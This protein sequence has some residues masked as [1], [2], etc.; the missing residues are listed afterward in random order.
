MAAGA[1]VTGAARGI[2][3]AI[4]GRLAREGYAVTA[5]DH[6]ASGLADAAARIAAQG[7]SLRAVAMDVTDRAAVRA[8]AQCIE[9]LEVV[10]NNAGVASPMTAFEAI[11]PDEWRR[12]LGVNTKGVFI[13]T[14]E[15]L[16]VLRPGG[17]IINIASRGYLGGA[18]AAHYVASKAAVVGLTRALAVELRWR[19]ISVNA[20]A[21]GMVDTPMIAAFTPQEMSALLAREPQGRPASPDAIADVAAFLA[22]PAARALNGQVIFADGGKTV[23][24]PPL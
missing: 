9:G 20:V 12:V 15:M 14:Q 2:G 8:V 7:L 6:D 18:G 3:L 4:A 19:G 16:R 5:T 13:V 17:R 23:G 1:I 24:M 22:S 10:V 11:S 21:P